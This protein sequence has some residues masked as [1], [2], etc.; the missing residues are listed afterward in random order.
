M[1]GLRCEFVK[2]TKFR[3]QSRWRHVIDILRHVTC[4]LSQD[5]SPNKSFSLKTVASQNQ[6][7]SEEYVRLNNSS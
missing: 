7:V 4:L 2:S 5:D 1:D 6:N 3:N